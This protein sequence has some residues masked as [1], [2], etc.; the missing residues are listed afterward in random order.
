MRRFRLWIKNSE[1]DKLICNNKNIIKNTNWKIIYNLD[2]GL[3]KTI[4]WFKKNKHLFD[5]DSKNFVV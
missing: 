1:V 4:T 2:K 3:D 5:T